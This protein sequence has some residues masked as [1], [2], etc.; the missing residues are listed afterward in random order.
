MQYTW[1]KRI[2]TCHPRVDQD[3]ILSLDTNYY[4]KLYTIVII[5]IS[6]FCSVDFYQIILKSKKPRNI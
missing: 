6:S 2:L 4:E 3:M 1:N 5:I